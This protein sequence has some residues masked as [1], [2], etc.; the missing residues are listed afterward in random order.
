MGSFGSG[1][2]FSPAAGAVKRIC[3]YPGCA[4]GFEAKRSDARY[5]SDTCRAQ[6]SKDRARARREGAGRR[7]RAGSMALVGA[8]GPDE[9]S[10]VTERLAAMEQR[11][12]TA[13]TAVARAQ[14]DRTDRADRADRGNVHQKLRAALTKVGDGR[15]PPSGGETAVASRP[16]RRPPDGVG[17]VTKRERDSQEE[18]DHYKV[19]THLLG[20][21]ERIDRGEGLT[22]EEIFAGV[23]DACGRRYRRWLVKR[24][25]L[26]ALKTE[27][28]R[29]WRPAKE[30]TSNPGAVARAAALGLAVEALADLEGTVHYDALRD[31]HEEARASLTTDADARLS[32]LTQSFQVRR[33]EAPRQPSRKHFIRDLFRAVEERLVCEIEHQLGSGEV[34]QYV[35]EPWGFVLHRGRLLLVA[36]KVAEA[37]KTRERRFFNVDGIRRLAVTAARGSPPP[38]GATQYERLFRDSFGIWLLSNPVLTKVHLQVRGSLAAILEQ[39]AMHHSQR[40]ARHD[41]EWLDVHFEVVV[42]PEFRAWVRSMI[43]D[44]RIVA[45]AALRHLLV[46]EVEGWLKTAQ[47]D[48]DR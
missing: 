43:P 32:R 20:F 13:E 34:R 22:D 47:S 46:S 11:P 40:E 16:R 42:C 10:A 12:S 44:V 39:R 7:T 41:V 5:C 48:P 29:V 9:A 35:I 33:P 8:A 3:A 27:R 45:P 6:A 24:R 2:F 18:P 31:L 1:S 14:A 36:G 26:K 15:A 23:E 37:V 21:I 28:G 17:L 19:A 25:N 38:A 4:G 30:P